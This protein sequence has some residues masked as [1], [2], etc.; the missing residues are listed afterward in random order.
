MKLNQK[1]NLKLTPQQL[2]LMKLL[3]VPVS[4]LDQTIKEEIEKNPL[5]EEAPQEES[6]DSN[7]V[8][9]E[10]SQAEPDSDKYQDENSINNYSSHK[11][12][13]LFSTAQVSFNDFLLEQF[14]LRPLS[15]REI[16][17]GQE[18]IGSLDEAGYLGRDINLITNDLAFKQNLE[19]TPD[20][21]LKVLDIIQSLD[22]AGV[23]A[24]DLK[25][26]LILQIR[27][28]EEE[29][30]KYTLAIEL[31]NHHFELFVRH[32]YDEIEK[33]MG[34]S[35]EQMKEITTL[36][37]ALNP[38][39]GSS[40]SDNGIDDGQSII[41]DF[42]IS[43]NEGETITFE[44]NEGDIPRP[45]MNT[46][47][48]NMMKQL[49]QKEHTS[50]Q[51]QTTLKFLKEKAQNAQDFIELFDQ[52][53]T[54]LQQIMSAIINYQRR[55]FSTGLTVDLRPMKLQDIATI[56]NYDISTISRVVNKKYIATPFGTF[57]L[58]ELFTNGFQSSD[59]E[60]V[61]TDII[62]E[63]LQELVRQEDRMNPLTDQELCLALREKG[64][65]VARRTVAKYR[66]MLHIA[67]AKERKGGI[68]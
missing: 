4:M 55:Y 12:Y 43:N 59:G 3:Q 32:N 40:L 34:I 57:L 65:P 7:T 21:V 14:M 30:D 15:D 64:Y 56:T 48:F 8:D 20:E 27:R 24:R 37:K 1:L 18:I 54:T 22:P 44:L 42:I 53:Q 47:Y 67:T 50:T 25:E 49:S 41:P 52:R 28:N 46:Y 10:M 35:S 13:T 66:E 11:G 9:I 60:I 62:K 68:Q 29:G 17:I 6:I 38:K 26:C 61:S 31:L 2:Q 19:T 36:I 45:R 33:L 63:T 16:L 5:L 58:K 23:G 39:P 51:E